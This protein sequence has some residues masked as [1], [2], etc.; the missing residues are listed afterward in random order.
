MGGNILISE[1]DRV[2][3]HSHKEIRHLDSFPSLCSQEK[4]VFFTLVPNLR[5]QNQTNVTR[6]TRLNR[7]KQR[8]KA[9]C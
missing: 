2:F 6:K 3:L 5:I 7:L 4:S 8:K 1:N 9:C